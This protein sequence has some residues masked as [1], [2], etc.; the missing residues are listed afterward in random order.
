MEGGKLSREVPYDAVS[1]IPCPICGGLVWDI[2]GDDYC[3]D[4]NTCLS[5]KEEWEVLCKEEL[6]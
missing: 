4:C 1:N 5:G 3:F 2:M 6:R